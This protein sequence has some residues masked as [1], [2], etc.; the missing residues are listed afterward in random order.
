MPSGWVSTDALAAVAGITRRGARKGA[1]AGTWRGSPLVVRQVRGRGGRSGWSYEVRVDSLPLDLQLRCKQLQSPFEAPPRLDDASA[2]ERERRFNIIRPALAFAKHTPERAEAVRE[3]AARE[4]LTPAGGV[5]RLSER[6]LQRWLNRYEEGGAAGLTRRQ[7]RDANK[8]KVFLTRAWDRAVSFDLATRERIKAEV[9]QDLRDLW[10]NGLS[11]GD[12]KRLASERLAD[13]TQA[14]G[15]AGTPAE[16]AAFCELPKDLVEAPEHRRAR[17]VH[18]YRTDRRAYED[19]R[20]RIIR[21]TDGL[22]P[23][24]LVFADIHHMD[25]LV[26]RPDGGTAT[27]KMIAWLDAATR[28]VR[29]DLVLCEPG[30]MVRNADVIESFI[31]MTQDPHWGMPAMLYLD[32]GSEFLFAD[33]ASDALKLAG[34]DVRQLD[35]NSPI[36]RAKAY[37]G[38]A[39]GLIEGFFGNVE[40]TIFAT[41]QG[42]I[43]GNRMKA[44]S[45]HLGKP[46]A[47]YNGTSEEFDADVQGSLHYYNG[48]QQTAQLKGLSPLQLYRRAVEGGWQRTDI[49]PNALLT[50][51]S[52]ED[53]RKVTDG[54]ISVDGTLYFDDALFRFEGENVAIRKPKYQSWPGIPFYGRDGRFIAVARPDVAYPHLSPEG[55]AEA[56]RRARVARQVMGDLGSGVRPIDATKRIIAS[57]RR[58]PDIAPPPSAGVIMLSKAQSQAGKALDETRAAR[59]DREHEEKQRKQ[60]ERL[61]LLQRHGYA[62]RPP[63][64]EG[65]GS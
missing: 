4:H 65:G 52:V 51:F 48:R 57:G 50:A 54:K 37:N 23:M 42:Y 22:A 58:E 30:T 47:P 19:R 33:F 59:R 29:A 18:Q 2:V 28:R 20:P 24:Q 13:L 27:P 25:V 6:N 9:L 26:T 21:T 1:K 49:D 39:K 43:G 60:R 53:R 40:R 41:V 55:A 10:G 63:A 61:E 3:I 12:V 62:P 15:F 64:P 46:Q 32:N 11:Y 16:I 5:E 44:R 45:A 38:P 36:V 8:P 7:R 35:R 31:R 34:L 56:D 17:R 14:A